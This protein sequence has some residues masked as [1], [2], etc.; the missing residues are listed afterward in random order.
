MAC[1]NCVDEKWKR[2]NI[3]Y[4]DHQWFLQKIIIPKYDYYEIPGIV[5]KYEILILK[6]VADI[7]NEPCVAE[8]EIK[9]HAN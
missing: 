6:K 4:D 3:A 9:C 2:I 5:K 7:M 8:G 1:I